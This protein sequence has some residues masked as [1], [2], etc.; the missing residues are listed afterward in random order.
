[1]AMEMPVAH[2]ESGSSPWPHT[3]QFDLTSVKL[4]ASSLLSLGFLLHFTCVLLHS[5]KI[6]IFLR[7]YAVFLNFLHSWSHSKYKLRLIHDLDKKSTLN[8]VFKIQLSKTKIDL[9]GQIL[10]EVF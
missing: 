9:L 4:P 3:D 8:H 10:W 7:Y 5:T 6:D 2:H 1:M